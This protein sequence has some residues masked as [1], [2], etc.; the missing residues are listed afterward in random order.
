ML[1][2]QSWANCSNFLSLFSPLKT[3]D[4]DDDDFNHHPP[5]SK[6]LLWKI[7]CGRCL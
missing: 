3:W 1:P 4:E 5:I 2:I 6:R 7:D